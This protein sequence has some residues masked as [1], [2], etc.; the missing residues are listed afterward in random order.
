MINPPAT[1]IYVS[2]DSSEVV[3]ITLIIAELNGVEVKMADVWML[4]FGLLWLKFDNNVGKV[5]LTT[6]AL[7]WLKSAGTGFRSH[8]EHCMH[9]LRYEWCYADPDLLMEVFTW[10]ND[11]TSFM[12]L[13]LPWWYLCIYHNASSILQCLHMNFP[14]KPGF[15]DP[16]LYF[17]A[18]LQPMK[19]SNSNGMNK[20]CQRC[21]KELQG[22]HCQTFNCLM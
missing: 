14:L 6:C 18:E 13:L 3:H 5:V 2:I 7:Y 9:Q 12:C 16:D 15:G 11:G 22:M 19:M 21:S 20:V 4:L 17:E 1:I 8:L 10:P